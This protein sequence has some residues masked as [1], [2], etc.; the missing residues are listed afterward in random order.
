MPGQKSIVPL[1]MSFEKGSDSLCTP[2]TSSTV[3]T[4]VSASI[5]MIRPILQLLQWPPILT[6]GA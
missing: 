1:K 3:N 2:L 4:A 5:G 6:C